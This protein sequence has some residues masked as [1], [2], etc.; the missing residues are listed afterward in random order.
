MADNLNDQGPQDQSRINVNEDDEVRYW[1]EELGVSEDRLREFVK[2]RATS[3]D[4]VRR[5]LRE[6]VA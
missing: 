5:A 6:R 2:Q 4:A 3:A 1:S